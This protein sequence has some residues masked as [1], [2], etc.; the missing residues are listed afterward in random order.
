VLALA[1]AT[2]LAVRVPAATAASTPPARTLTATKTDLGTLGFRY[3]D[4]VAVEGRWVVC[5]S[6]SPS[7]RR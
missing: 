3:S 7:S 6:S 4:A 1:T 5:P 2:S